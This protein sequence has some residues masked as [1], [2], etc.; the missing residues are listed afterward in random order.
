MHEG[1]LLFHPGHILVEIATP[2]ADVVAKSGQGHRFFIISV[3]LTIFCSI[4]AT[5]LHFLCVF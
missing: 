4:F 3:D 1:T 2:T 5:H